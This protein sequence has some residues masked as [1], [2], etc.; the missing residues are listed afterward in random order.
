[1]AEPEVLEAIFRN[2]AQVDRAHLLGELAYRHLHALAELFQGW[3]TEPGVAPERSAELLGM[4]EGLL[5]LAA[6]VGPGWNPPDPP[7][8]SLI[9]YM[10]R[11]MLGEKLPPPTPQPDD[12]RRPLLARSVLA[13]PL[14][15]FEHWRLV[16]ACDA[17]GTT[18]GVSIADLGLREGEETLIGAVLPRL[19]CRHCGAAPASITLSDGAP[20]DI[21]R[22]VRLG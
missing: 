13:S 7:T 4:A 3:A 10:P 16:L 8:V 9:G 2:L 19:R 21:E 18:R 5:D 20:A 11:K 6:Q 12:P 14:W 17:C 1:M 22:V 15:L